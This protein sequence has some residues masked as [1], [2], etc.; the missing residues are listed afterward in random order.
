MPHRVGRLPRG[1]T[2]VSMPAVPARS[3]ASSM[4]CWPCSS[5]STLRTDA[6]GPGGSPWIAAV[7]VRR[8]MSRRISASMCSAARRWRSSGSPT[9]PSARTRSSRSLADRS[10]APE[11]AAARQRDPLVAERHLGQRPALVHLA[12]EVRRGQAHVGEEHL[13]ERCA[14]PVISMIGRISMPGVSIGQMKYEMPWCFGDVGVGAG[15][16]DAELRHAAR[17]TSR[18][19]GR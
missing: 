2:V 6:S 16:E 9:P 4:M 13:V 5:A 10:A 18:S 17:P 3:L 1:S 15:D 11:R 12:D 14:V 8:R 7:T 19:S